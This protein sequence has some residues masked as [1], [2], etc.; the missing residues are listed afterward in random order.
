MTLTTS[1]LI[2]LALASTSAAFL[3][4]SAG[5]RTWLGVS[6]L[7]LALGAYITLTLQVIGVPEPSPLGTLAWMLAS[8]CGGGVLFYEHTKL[9]NMSFAP[10][11]T[12]IGALASTLLVVMGAAAI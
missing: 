12:V 9:Q 6:A 7:V 2:L 1:L 3:A 4:S 10:K 8:S 5:T 11:M